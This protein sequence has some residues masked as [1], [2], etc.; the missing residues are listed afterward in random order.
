MK[1]GFTL[2][3]LLVVIS[4]IALL[5]VI[6]LVNINTARQKSRDV[7]RIGDIQQIITAMELFHVDHGRYPDNNDGISGSGECVG[8]GVSCGQSNA[9]EDAEGLS[10]M[11]I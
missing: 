6:V 5:A 2:I 4:I 7:K 8:D 3:E 11:F 10:Q 1:K 9:F